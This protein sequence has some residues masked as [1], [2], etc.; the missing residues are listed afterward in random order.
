L[1]ASLKFEDMKY[2]VAFWQR[3]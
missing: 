1:L 2:E 3:C